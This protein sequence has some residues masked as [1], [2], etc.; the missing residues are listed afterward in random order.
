MKKILIALLCM[1]LGASMMMAQNAEVS[2]GT[3]NSKKEASANDTVNNYVDMPFDIADFFAMLDNREVLLVDY[4]SRSDLVVASKEE[5]NSDGFHAFKVLEKDSINMEL[6]FENGFEYQVVRL[7]KGIVALIKTH[8]IPQQD[9]EIV[10]FDE[11]HTSLSADKY[12]K[13][14]K[15]KDWLT[16]EGKKNRKIVEQKVPFLIVKYH[17]N[18]KT[19]ILTL[20]N[21]LKD[22]FIINEWDELA[23]Y[24]KSELKYKW[25]KKK[26]NQLKNYIDL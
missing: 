4:A 2:T 11:N 17:Y 6:A 26:F 7:E 9:S 22:Y 1:V 20:T 25:N 18:P 12:F 24:F 13:A 14:P 10:F 3:L 5:I 15:L 8:V 19:S 16:D 23:P 21:N